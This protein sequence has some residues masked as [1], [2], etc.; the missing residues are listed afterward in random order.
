MNKWMKNNFLK[1]NE[2]KTEVLLVGLKSKRDE[3]FQT[4]RKLTLM[5][6]YEVTN[7]GVI[8]DS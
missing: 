6:K 8:L 5:I 1:L 2:D 7:L 4:L 3:L